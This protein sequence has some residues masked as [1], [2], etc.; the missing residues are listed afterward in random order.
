MSKIYSFSDYDKYMSLKLD[1]EMWLIIVYFLRPFI[2]KVST[3]QMGRGVKSASVSGLKDLVYPHDFSF[4]IAF[5][6]TIPVIL[7][8]IAYTKR[9]PGAS[10]WV[11]TIWRNGKMLLVV[12]AVLNIIIIFVPFLMDLTH[13]INLFGWGQ[14]AVAIY[15]LYHLYTRQRVRDTFADFPGADPETTKK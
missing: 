12:T 15:I 8:V 3:I 10:E 13:R 1:F 2:L 4:F 5:L 14:L 9:R 7:L 11:R 6:A